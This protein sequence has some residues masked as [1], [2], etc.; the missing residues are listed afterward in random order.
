MHRR[1]FHARGG[2]RW[3]GARRDRQNLAVKLSHDD[4]R[5]WAATRSIEP[6]P[7]AYSDL[8][9]LPDGTLLCFYESGR[10]GATRPNSTRTDWPYARLTLARF[11]LEWLAAAPAASP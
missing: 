7:C 1:G 2:P 8:A 9:V 4:G 11:N 6:G 5:T 3:P 10:P